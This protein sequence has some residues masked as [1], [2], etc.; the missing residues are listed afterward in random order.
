MSV[1]IMEQEPGTEFLEGDEDSIDGKIAELWD[2]RDKLQH[3]SPD[4]QK[5]IGVSETFSLA[6]ECLDFI[7]F[8]VAADKKL[9]GESFNPDRLDYLL[10]RFTLPSN[11]DDM[12]DEEK[13]ELEHWYKK[14]LMKKHGS[15]N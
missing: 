6:R 8:I 2:A 4:S 13:K 15:K 10:E 7:D 9:F 14:Y 12:T 11:G 1:E 3:P 5:A